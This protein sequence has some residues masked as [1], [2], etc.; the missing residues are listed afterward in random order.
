ME[1]KCVG[2]LVGESYCDNFQFITNE[3]LAPKRLE[4]VV[5]KESPLQM[6]K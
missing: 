2:Y 6:R 3:E 5:I 1:L 4:Y